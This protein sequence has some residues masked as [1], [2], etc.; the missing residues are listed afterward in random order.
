MLYFL[1]TPLVDLPINVIICIH[2][3]HGH[4]HDNARKPDT[5]PNKMTLVDLSRCILCATVIRRLVMFQQLEEQV[6]VT[7]AL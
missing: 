7:Q 6:L 2:S 1:D 4:V 3:R 5:E